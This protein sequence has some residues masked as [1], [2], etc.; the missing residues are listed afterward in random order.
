MPVA[1]YLA[2]LQKVEA[3]ACGACCPA[4]QVDHLHIAFAWK[5]LLPPF[6]IPAAVVAATSD[7]LAM[8]GDTTLIEVVV[9]PL[10]DEEHLAAFFEPVAAVA[11]VAAAA[12]VAPALELLH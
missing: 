6:H 10:V 3:D 2:C 1:Y 4:V 5:V 11:V 12:A 9:K 7:L 8:P